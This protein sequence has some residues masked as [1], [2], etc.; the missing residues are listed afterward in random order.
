MFIQRILITPSYGG[1]K[2][3]VERWWKIECKLFCFT[4]R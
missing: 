2:I 1:E 3:D 4:A